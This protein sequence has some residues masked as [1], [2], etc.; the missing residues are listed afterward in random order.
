ML[1]QLFENANTAN[2]RNIA[3]PHFVVVT[4]PEHTPHLHVVTV[5]EHTPHLHVVVVAVSIVVIVPE[6]QQPESIYSKET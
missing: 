4:V 5:P 3:Q 2:E 6:Q 1:L